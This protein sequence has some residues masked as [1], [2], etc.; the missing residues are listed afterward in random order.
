MSNGL[1][2]GLPSSEP[3]LWAHKA[4]A[5]GARGQALQVPSKT[6]TLPHPLPKAAAAPTCHPPSLVPSS[7]PP[8][9]SGQGVLPGSQ[10]PFHIS[11]CPAGQSPFTEGGEGAAAPGYRGGGQ[12]SSLRCARPPLPCLGPRPRGL[13]EAPASFQRGRFP[14]VQEARV[15]SSNEGD[16]GIH[17]E[18]KSLAGTNLRKQCR[19]FAMWSGR[20]GG[21]AESGCWLFFFIPGSPGPQRQGQRRSPAKSAPAAL[22]RAQPRCPCCAHLLR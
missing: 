22:M 7:D 3:D 5:G 16:W 4:T 21:G 10:W 17:M 1:E 11:L 20:L 9:C 6:R 19:L 18:T 8:P 12:R 2:I 14:S 13:Q 15:Q